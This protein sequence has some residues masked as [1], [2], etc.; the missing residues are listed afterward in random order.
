MAT[1]DKEALWLH[2]VMLPSDLAVALTE[3]AWAFCKI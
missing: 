3:M 1:L 2:A